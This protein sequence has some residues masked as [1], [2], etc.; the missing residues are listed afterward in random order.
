MA[1]NGHDQQLGVVVL[2]AVHSERQKPVTGFAGERAQHQPLSVAELDLDMGSLRGVADRVPL[3]R[4]QDARDEVVQRRFRS[5]GNPEIRTQ[6]SLVSSE[7]APNCSRP[8]SVMTRPRG[9]RWMN[10]S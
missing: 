8:S 1:P 3:D 2:L 5:A 9:V 10:P 7:A 4:L 6:N